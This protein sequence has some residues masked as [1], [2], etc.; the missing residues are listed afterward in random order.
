MKKIL[1]I[2]VTVLAMVAMMVVPGA[3]AL[4][5]PGG[6]IAKPGGEVNSP[7]DVGIG[8]RWEGTYQT[9]AP[10]ID[11]L[12][13][14]L[15]VEN[16][17]DGTLIADT[18]MTKNPGQDNEFSVHL[19]DQPGTYN[20]VTGEIYLQSFLVMHV[21]GFYGG[22]EDMIL[23]TENIGITDDPAEPT[24]ITCDY[25]SVEYPNHGTFQ[26]LT[27]F[28]YDHSLLDEGTTVLYKVP[29]GRDTIPGSRDDNMKG[30]WT[31]D[32]DSNPNHLGLYSLSFDITSDNP[33]TL[34]LENVAMWQTCGCHNMRAEFPRITGT[35]SGNNMAID[36]NLVFDTTT[37]T[38]RIIIHMDGTVN[39]DN[40]RID[41]GYN[42]HSIM[43]PFDIEI[44]NG[45]WFAD[46][47]LLPPVVTSVDTTSGGL[48]ESISPFNVNGQRFRTD[49]YL[50][51]EVT[52]EKVGGTETITGTNVEVQSASLITCNIVIPD[53]PS[54]EGTYDLV[55]HNGVWPLTLQGCF[56]VIEV[57]P[58]IVP[59]LNPN[60]G[61]VGTLVTITGER[62]GDPQGGSTVTFD[63][64]NVD[65]LDT[66]DDPDY[67]SWSDTQIVCKVPTDATTGPVV[68]T[69]D[70]EQSNGVQFT[71]L[72]PVIVPPL[73]PGSGP[74]DDT[75]TIDGQNFGVT[76]GTSTVTF[77]GV[78]ADTT[79]W[80]S[81]QIVCTVP[82]L[83]PGEVMVRVNT[84][85]GP[86]NEVPF[87]VIVPIPII[88]GVTPNSGMQG[89]G[90]PG[91]TLEVTITGEYTNFDSTSVVEFSGGGI[92]VSVPY[93]VNPNGLEL[94]VDITIDPDATPGSRDVTVTTGGEVAPGPGLFE[95]IQRDLPTVASINPNWGNLDE[96]L[97][98]VTITGTNFM[99][100]ATVTLVGT[101]GQDDI[102]GYS[103]QVPSNTEITCQITIPDDPGAPGSYDV[104]VTNLGNRPGTLTGGFTVPDLVE[105][106]PGSGRPD[107]GLTVTITGENTNFNAL[108]VVSFSGTGISQN[109]PITVN[110]ATE[111]VVIIDIDIAALQGARDVTVTTPMPDGRD[112]VAIGE[113]LFVVAEASIV[114]V[115]PNGGDPGDVFTQILITGDGTHF[116]QGVS[117]AD[118]GEDIQVSPMTVTSDTE[119]SVLINILTEAECGLRDVVVTTGAEVAI[120]ADIFAVGN[121][122][123]TGD[124][125]EGSQEDR[126]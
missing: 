44:D 86:S 119:G 96:T 51:N 97:P 45:T 32:V 108:S 37:G 2:A 8:G 56:E 5:K 102:N 88:T 54:Y 20:S 12:D 74:V 15:V 92:S 111:I 101:T 69:V 67:I 104:V 75:V 116:V 110:G 55:G 46:K 81:N 123:A 47:I 84:S 10:G 107:S 121:V 43:G 115:D 73:N 99:E 9:L 34:V 35:Y 114:A 30:S 85:G 63:G 25:D 13:M 14:V 23:E 61:D 124:P 78:T 103:I 57:G 52:L 18:I 38:T 87:T 93:D 71:V 94:K 118:F 125:S 40:N 66:D 64:I 91:P 21:E 113:G 68:V 80:T 112:E 36:L 82:Q 49:P 90:M 126:T 120:G 19:Y 22:E 3:M 28:L 6:A 17:G 98:P 31:G 29:E 59:P 83:D 109:L 41:G 122:V 76:K 16:Q 39:V 95:V 33:P 4:S 89:V 117:V 7:R 100:G 60:E 11:S 50:E 70:G 48:G 77:D 1:L 62:F 24:E 79:V 106:D 27:Y 42:M 53:D 26:Y 58:V 65:D 105:A 72:P